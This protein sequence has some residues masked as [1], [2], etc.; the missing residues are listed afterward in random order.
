MQKAQNTIKEYYPKFE[1]IKQI[2]PKLFEYLNSISEPEIDRLMTDYEFEIPGIEIQ[3]DNLLRFDVL[4]LLKAGNK[5][6][7]ET[8]E[9]IKTKIIEK[10]EKYFSKYSDKLKTALK[11]YFI[12]KKSP[13]VNWK[14]NYY[15]LLPFIYNKAKKRFNNTDKLYHFTSFESAVKIIASKQL[16]YGKLS[17]MNDINESYKN[18]YYN[19]E[20]SIEDI[21]KECNRYRQISLTSDDKYKNKKGFLITPMWAHYAEKGYGVCLVFDKEKLLTETDTYF[22]DSITYTD[23]FNNNIN[24]DNPNISQFFKENKEDLFFKKKTEWSNEQEY[25]II[26]RLDDIFKFKYFNIPENSFVAIIMCRAKGCED[27]SVFDS[28]E[29]KYLENL[30]NKISSDIPIVELGGFFD[31]ISLRFKNGGDTLWNSKKLNLI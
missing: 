6:S 22:S 30:A 20:I 18:F 25:R 5:I 27:K 28:S 8:I 10:D 14:D 12:K 2:D 7:I 15:L 17:D 11:S 19:K 24:V 23:S 16:R 4:N 1:E 9:S 31:D 29:Y 21:K 3:P 13:F 26:L